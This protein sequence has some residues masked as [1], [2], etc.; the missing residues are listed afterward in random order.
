M[1]ITIISLV[2]SSVT[3]LAAVIGPIVSSAITVRSNE[4]T[5]RFEQY[6]PQQYA[7][8][9]RFSNAYSDYPR[10][11][12]LS[13]RNRNREALLDSA[14]YKY[15]E[16]CAAAYGVMSFIASKE[17]HTQ[18]I[19]FLESIQASELAT[20]KEDAMFQELS[21]LLSAELASQLSEQGERNRRRN[22]RTRSK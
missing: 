1:D 15:K 20:P 9:Q 18:T 13:A 16:L 7:A 14:S 17:I 5:K 12:E 6:A 3:A 10:S 4:R 19:A 2:L 21:A 11:N 22:K 8:V